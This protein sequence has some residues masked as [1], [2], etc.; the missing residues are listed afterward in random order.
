MAIKIQ[1]KKTSIPVTIGDLEF[2][3]GVSDESAKQFREE[4]IK[5]KNELENIAISEDD[6]QAQEQTKDILKRGF[7]LMLGEGSFEK[8]YELSPSV[9]ILTKYFVQLADGIHE[10]ITELN[11]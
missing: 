7:D 9:I 11:K 5:V 10:E 1:T 4:A 6:D 3:F 2:S 8:I